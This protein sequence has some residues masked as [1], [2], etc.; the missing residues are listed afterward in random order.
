MKLRM[1]YRGLAVLFAAG[2]A[3][4][5]AS[6]ALAGQPQP[7]TTNAMTATA[8]AGSPGDLCQ[9]D[10]GIEWAAISSPDGGAAVVFCQYDEILWLCDTG[11]DH[12]PVS[13]FYWSKDAQLHVVEKFPGNGF[14]EGVDLDIPEDGHINFRAC[15]Y[16][17]NTA[18]S[19]S[20]FTGRVSAG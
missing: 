1:I 8:P 13:R 6:V 20:V 5:Q 18:V 3:V 9:P 14:C 7:A 17:V 15:N 19:C 2:L 16:E 12:H 11:P 10:D 4:T